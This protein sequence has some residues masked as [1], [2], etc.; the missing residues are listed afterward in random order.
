[1]TKLIKSNLNMAVF[2]KKMFFRLDYNLNMRHMSCTITIEIIVKSL[3][4]E[5]IIYVNK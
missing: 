5:Q 1:M 4:S 2:I 3:E